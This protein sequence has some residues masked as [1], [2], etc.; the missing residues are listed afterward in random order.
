MS[1]S[2]RLLNGKHACGDTEPR[3]E[4]IGGVSDYK[5]KDSP[6]EECDR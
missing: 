6:V 2:S 5:W 1:V 4:E 3:R